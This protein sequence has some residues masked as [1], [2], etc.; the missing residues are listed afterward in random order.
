MANV[1]GKIVGDK[2][3]LEIDVSDAA[4]KAAAP[5]KTGKTQIVASTNGFT[6]Y[7]KGVKV[8]L[9]ATI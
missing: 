9:N 8:S 4:L 3:I 1:T 2:L 6:S 7:G 5:S